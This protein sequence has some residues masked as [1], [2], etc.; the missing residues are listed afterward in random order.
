VAAY[1][2]TGWVHNVRAAGEVTLTRSG[3]SEPLRA[4]E[5]GPREAV[6]VLRRY[7]EAVPVTRPYFGVSPASGDQEFEA[8]TSRHPL[9]RLGPAR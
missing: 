4:V 5:V 2:V 9:F 3:R 6:P 8:E 1:G 7:L